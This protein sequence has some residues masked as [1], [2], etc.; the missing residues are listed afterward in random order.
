MNNLILIKL[1]GSVITD[2]NLPYVAKPKEI[3]RLV[4]ELKPFAKNIIIAHGSGSFGHTSA[5]K[6]GGKK[7]YKSKVGI[8][9]VARDASEINRIVIDIFINENIP[10]VSLRPMSMIL[11]RNGKMQKNFFQI[12]ESVVKQG[13]IPVVY[14]DVIWDKEWKST[15]FSGETT[16]SYVAKYLLKRGFKI[17]KIIEVSDTNGVND[18]KGK[19]IPEITINSWRQQKIYIS[20]S[21]VSDVTGGMSH[22]IEEALEISKMKIET[23]IINGNIKNELKNALMNKKT[24]GTLIK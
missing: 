21:K 15:I 4:K 13:L 14:G 6:Y 22:K 3:R 18:E 11:A 23:L 10:V 1:G 12:I 16:L 9:K 20:K 2:K 7:G 19:T 8:A 17:N 5:T 24:G